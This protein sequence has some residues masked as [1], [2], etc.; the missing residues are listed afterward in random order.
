[1]QI[2][3]AATGPLVCVLF[4]H[5][6]PAHVARFVVAVVVDSV[7]A[8]IW[9]FASSKNL[10]ELP[11]VLES[12]LYSTTTIILKRCIVGIS[13]ATFSGMKNGVL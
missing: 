2:S 6:R 7:D 10:K 13:A 12:K 9:R 8:Q 11:K 1:M 3:I 4:G 5:S